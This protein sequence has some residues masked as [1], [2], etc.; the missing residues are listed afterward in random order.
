MKNSDQIKLFGLNN[1]AV[2]AA[3]KGAEQKTGIEFRP[4]PQNR[5]QDEEYYPQFPAE[6]RREAEQM[7][8]QY[9]LCCCLETSIRQ[10][11]VDTLKAQPDVAADWWNKMVP[12]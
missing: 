4:P 8:R 2:E 7:A 6:I 9:E 5:G 11:V 12:E 10:L 1:L 3:I